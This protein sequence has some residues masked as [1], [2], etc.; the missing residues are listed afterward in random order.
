MLN[1]QQLQDQRTLQMLNALPYRYGWQMG[2][3]K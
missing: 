3:G 2:E 1:A